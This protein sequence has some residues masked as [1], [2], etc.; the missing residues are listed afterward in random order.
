[1]FILTGAVWGLGAAFFYPASMAYSL[2]FVGSSSG[3]V[4][5]ILRATMDFGLAVGPMVTGLIVPFTGYSRMFLYLSLMALA[6]F[7]YFQFYVRRKRLE[8]R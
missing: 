4:L 1:M 8:F 2:E 7:C 3:T 6:N 5:G